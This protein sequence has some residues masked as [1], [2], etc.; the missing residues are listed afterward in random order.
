MAE[1]ASRFVS[2]SKGIPEHEIKSRLGKERHI[3]NDLTQ[4][5]EIRLLGDRYFPGYLAF[6]EREADTRNYAWLATST[7]LEALKRLYAVKGPGQ[8]EFADVLKASSAVNPGIHPR[9]VNLGLLMAADFSEFVGG[10]SISGSDL[11]PGADVVTSIS[12]REAILDFELLESSWQKEVKKREALA[13]KESLISPPKFASKDVVSVLSSEVADFSFVRDEVLRQVVARDYEEVQSIKSV[14]AVKSRLVLAG[15]LV[16]ALLLDSLRENQEGAMTALRAEKDRDGR[17]KPLEEW[18]LASLIDV[19][20]ELR[21][22]TPAV[23][24]FSHGIRD[25]RNLIH[26]G[27][28]VRST[29]KLGAEE[30]DIAEKVLEI[31]IRDLKSKTVGRA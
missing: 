7:V 25:Y 20:M 11:L 28:E 9:S 10:Y 24:K 27:K 21:L 5:G 6:A 29:H 17:V 23:E 13:E 4:R 15:G 14:R 22:I 2:E 26:P 31:V 3:L 19:A 8:L 16:E 1:I 30:A 12:V 18:H